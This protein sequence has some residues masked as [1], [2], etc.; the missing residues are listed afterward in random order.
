MAYKHGVYNAEQAT[1]LTT[2]IQGS[3][4]LQVIFGTAPIHLAKNPAEAANTPKLC[5]SFAECQEAVGYSDNFKDFTIC[6][7]IDACFRVFNVAPIILI[8]VL[9]PNK[10]AHTTVNAAEEVPVQD[11]TAVYTKPN[12]LLKTLEVKNGEAVLVPGSDYVATHDDSGKVLITLLAEAARE[13]ESLT[14][15]SKSVNPAGVTRADVVGGVDTMTGKETG[16]ELVR[17]IYPK[18][19]M[20][21]GILL[22][23]GWSQDA[24]VAAAL[25]AKTEAINGVFDCTA[26]LDIAADDNGATVGERNRSEFFGC[27]A[28]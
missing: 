9:D 18:F 25:Q 26:Y 16:M 2:P 19:G 21:P 5:D 10:P 11:A 6:Q 12:V 24:V 8:N 20:V 7:S 22:A 27:R 14:V 1:S 15:S 13:A 28:Q 4:G 17:H 23:P 3:A